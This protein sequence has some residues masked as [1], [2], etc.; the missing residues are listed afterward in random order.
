[1]AEAVEKSAYVIICVSK[2]YLNRPNCEQEAKFARALEKDKKLTIIYVMMQSDFT[3]VSQPES[4]EGWLRLYLGDKLWYPL[5]DKG[6]VESTGDAIA[7]I[8]GDHAKV[9]T[10]SPVLSIPWN[11]LQFT[12]AAD[13]LIGQ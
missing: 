4:V 5:W 7:G 3:T 8:I 9:Q 13:D 12:S 11:S 1:M 2:P 6:Q 10:T